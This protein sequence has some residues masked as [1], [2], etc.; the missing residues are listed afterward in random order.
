MYPLY[1]N[2]TTTLYSL[3]FNYSTTLYSLYFNYTLTLYSLY[4]NYATT[5][6]SLYFN[7][8]TTLHS[9]YFL[10]ILDLERN[11]IKP[12]TKLWFIPKH[13]FN[14]RVMFALLLVHFLEVWTNIQSQMTVGIKL[15]IL[16]H[17]WWCRLIDNFKLYWVS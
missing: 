1:L 12:T 15:R 6:F 5:L 8:T 16:E 13:V 7:Y 10:D 17:W 9:L 3:Y 2:Y 11:Y 14:N 4:F